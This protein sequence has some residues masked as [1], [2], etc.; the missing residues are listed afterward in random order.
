M[1]VFVVLDTNEIVAAMLTRHNDSA[2][3]RIID[4][5]TDLKIQVLY[6]KDILDEYHRILCLK[7]FGF[8]P[9]A[10]RD[11]ENVIT[12]FGIQTDRTPTDEFFTD[13]DDMVFYEV[14]LSKDGT[15]MVTGNKRHFPNKPIVVTPTEMIAILEEAGIIDKLK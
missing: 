3:K 15:Y 12:T 10:I 1:K 5:I 11:M 2:T 4:A 7:K 9:D 13:P 6:H 14:A 8:P